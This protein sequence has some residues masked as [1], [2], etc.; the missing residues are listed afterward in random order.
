[1]A[2]DV[3]VYVET[4]GGDPI[5][6][7]TIK[8]HNSSSKALLQTSTTDA[9]GRA[10]F[11]AVDPALNSGLYEIRI[12]CGFP[13]D[14]TNGNLQNITVL[15]GPELPLKNEF[16]VTVTPEALPTAVNTNLCRCSGYFRDMRGQALKDV[17]IRVFEER[18]PNIEYQSSADYK[19]IA[20]VPK[21]RVLRTDANGYVSVDLYRDSLYSILVQ[22]YTNNFRQVKTPDAAA[23]NL[24]DI[25]FPVVKTVRWYDAGVQLLP[26]TAPTV[27]LTVGA[28]KEL[29]IIA[30]F[31][32]A[33]VADD[34][35]VTLTS[36]NTS[37]VTVAK[38]G[39]EVTLR[40]VAAGTAN[41]TIARATPPTGSG[42]ITIY[43]E[44]AV[45]GTLAVTVA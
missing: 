40:P 11:V 37:V 27:S 13:C 15:D 16:T 21:E 36:S 31:F 20:V 6:N 23:A 12:F 35:E 24:V 10:S 17:N 38:S 1:M 4:G 44:P 2:E 25:I 19:S 28:N 29:T 5:E 9:T 45:V 26:S 7:A 22:N 32:S 34:S 39:D 18:I 41:I 30:S 3:F 8:L 14:I 33:V 43:P 42:G